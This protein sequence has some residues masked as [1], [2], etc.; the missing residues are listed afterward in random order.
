VA[1]KLVGK[2]VGEI[3]EAVRSGSATPVDAVSQHLEQIASL[4]DRVGAFVR[5]RRERALAEADAVAA[6][7][8]LAELPLAG[9]PIAIKD[10][11]QVEGEPTRFGCPQTSV[12]PADKDHEVVARLR[13]AGAVVVGIT[14]LPELGVFGTTEDVWGVA[15]NPWKLEV[16]PGGSSGGSAAAV[17]AAMVPVAHGNDGLG[18]IR[19][20]AACCGLFG[21]K[22]GV[23]V[24]P[25]GVATT[26]DDAAL[27]LSVM[28][29]DPSLA[30]VGPP[31]GKLRVAVSTKVPLPGVKVDPE[32]LA[33]VGATAKALVAAGH[34]VTRADPP[35]SQSAANAV[36]A[37][38]TA[39]TADET[40]GLDESKLEPRQR[41]HA[42]IGRTLERLGRVRQKDRDRFKERAGE[43]FGRFDVLVT[44]VMTKQPPVADGWPDRSWRANFFGNARWAPFS[45][46]WNFAQYPG[47]AV[48]AGIHSNGTPMS[49]QIV[50]PTG[51]EALLLSV[52]KQLEQAR[53]WPRH[54]PLAGV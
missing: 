42:Q 4:D 29:D 48:P 25:S 30:T 13:A 45:A 2:T 52:A 32:T 3:A 35:Y 23:G 51:G 16:T 44:P 24:V 53:P 12:E 38:F 15:R 31:A 28:A 20:P 7:P 9:V 18:S 43:F 14:R 11:V 10:N 6:R 50:A 49:V 17:A 8:E 47:A 37:W 54:A 40:K 33:A 39:A 26:V 21:I 22:P 36:V 46:S 5:V 27:L 19:I 41:R 1:G 34:D